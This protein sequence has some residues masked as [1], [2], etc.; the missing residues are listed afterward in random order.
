MQPIVDCTN[1]AAVN[2]S[3]VAIGKSQRTLVMDH[4]MVVTTKVTKV[5]EQAKETRHPQATLKGMILTPPP[6]DYDEEGPMDDSDGFDPVVDIVEDLGT[7]RYTVPE[8]LPGMIDALNCS[9]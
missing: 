6:L 8:P 1:L 9:Y 4:N 5:P 7:I 3:T 2:L